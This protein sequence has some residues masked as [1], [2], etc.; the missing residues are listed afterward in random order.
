MRQMSPG[1]KVNEIDL[2]IVVPRFGQS[3]T[4]FGGKF[5]KG[6]S[7]KYLLIPNAEVLIETYGLPTNDNFNDWFQCYNYLQYSNKLLISRA[8]D[9]NGT[10]KITDNKVKS[11][12]KWKIEIE[13]EP[14]VTVGDY[15]AFNDT[16]ENVY[17]II[18]IDDPVDAVKQ[19]DELVINSVNE[20]DIFKITNRGQTVSVTATADDT[21]SSIAVSL[22]TLIEDI[23]TNATNVNVEDNKITITASIA[24][25]SMTNIIESGDMTLTNKVENVIGKSYILEIEEDEELDF[26]NMTI[27]GKNIY[28][29]EK[30]YNPMVTAPIVGESKQSAYDLKLEKILIENEDDYDTMETSIGKNPLV[31]LKFIGKSFGSL[32]NGVE[33]AIAKEEDFNSGIQTVFKNISLNALFEH[34]PVN[35]NKEIAIVIR[36]GDQI[37]ET[38]LVSLIPGAKDYRNRSI[39]I[40][41]ILNNYS[42]YVYCK[43][44]ELTTKDVASCLYTNEELNEDGT[45]KTPAI[46]KLLRL[47]NGSD[48][49]IGYGDIEF[50]YGNVSENTIFG[51]K[52]IIDID[53]IISNEMNQLAAGNLARDRA[54]C[55]AIH[56]ALYEHTVGL[57]STKIVENLIKETKLGTLNKIADS[58]NAFYGNYKK[59]YDKWNDKFRWVNVAGDVA[60]TRALTTENSDSWFANA[61]LYAEGVGTIKNTIKLAFNPALGNR[62]FMYKNRIN[63]IVEF[64]GQGVVIWGQKLLLA[65]PSALNRVNVRMLF[66]QIERSMSRMARYYVFAINDEYT[67]NAIVARLNPYLETIK[68]GRGIYDYFVRCDETNNPPSL[69]DD[70]QLVIDVFVKPARIAEFIKLNVVASPTGVNLQSLY[71]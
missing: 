25:V 59:Q 66:N 51:Q 47:S 34:K 12:E 4:A 44:N 68:A 49:I 46:D 3:T 45:I 53:I 38:H 48:G 27:I 17:K 55:L 50:A 35:S 5:T 13:N 62:D 56:G 36:D 42:D 21:L 65:K 11:T 39:Y 30:S 6:P 41:D 16:D 61:G 31:K 28:W 1:V 22:G 26:T 58:Y 67:R 60:G 24:G 70:N 20:D 19:V 33:I 52:E 37:V 8:V 10:L 32:N 40:E 15:I 18:K 63:P 23:D 64:P 7:G 57:K 54:D 14:E 2:S 29:Q 69:I 9:S 71:I 43:V